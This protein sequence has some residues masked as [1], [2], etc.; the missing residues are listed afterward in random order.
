[1]SYPVLEFDWRKNGLL[2]DNIWNAQM[3]GHP[4]I[5]TYSGPDLIVR[6][7]TRSGA[8]HFEHLERRYEIPHVLSR[9]EYPFACTL[10]GGKSS[11]VGHIPGRENSSQGG[12]ITVFLREHLIAPDRHQTSKFLVKV[13]NHP[14]GPVTATCKPTCAAC[15]VQCQYV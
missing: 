8:M 12:M 7:V 15:G 5:L 3:A 11:W 10:E 13:T 4:K 6:H 14:R 2:A 9:D 1:M